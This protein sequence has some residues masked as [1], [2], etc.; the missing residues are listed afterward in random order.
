MSV[1]RNEKEYFWGNIE[2]NTEYEKYPEMKNLLKEHICDEEFYHLCKA[3]ID[4]SLNAPKFPNKEDLTVEA[5]FQYSDMDKAKD[6][7]Y[8]FI[9]KFNIQNIEDL[10]TVVKMFYP[11]A[12]HDNRPKSGTLFKDAPYN[13]PNIGIYIDFCRMPDE[14]WE[15]LVQEI[16]NKK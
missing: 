14:I 5:C 3:F 9:D 7:T 10:L 12:S 4:I 8:S 13:S 1:Y 2:N 16:L 15:K 11:Y 6:A